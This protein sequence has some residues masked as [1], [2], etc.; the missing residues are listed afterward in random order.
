M[1]EGHRSSK[2]SGHEVT[3]PA[4]AGRYVYTSEG[5]LIDDFRS[6]RKDGRIFRFVD[7]ADALDVG[8]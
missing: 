5:A 3:G 2:P 4:S 8:R 6:I 1:G 7:D